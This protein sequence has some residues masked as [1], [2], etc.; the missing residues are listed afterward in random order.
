M[1]ATESENQPPRPT[2]DVPTIPAPQPTAREEMVRKDIALRLRNACSGLTEHDF[3]QLV[4]RI[5]Q[6]QLTG[7][8]K[9]H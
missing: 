7:E 1:L 6:V 9:G 2:A 4:E 3:A 5:L 8:R